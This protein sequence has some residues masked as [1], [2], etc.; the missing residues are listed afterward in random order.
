MFCLLYRSLQGSEVEFFSFLIPMEKLFER[1]I[2]K[3]IEG[4]VEGKVQV[5]R[6][7]GHL[8][9]KDR[10]KLFYLV[11]DVVLESDTITVIDTKYKLLDPEDRKMGI[12]QQDLYQMYA[13]CKEL[14]SK[15]CVL[16]YPEGLNG[17]ISCDLSLGKEGID[18][19]VRTLP[20]EN[21]FEN[22]R[23]S[24]EFVKRL[25]NVMGET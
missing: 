3:S 19:H 24:D 20:L 14:N 9:E 16:I 15:R 22:S 12:S 10:K 21:I 18:L 8:A 6:P 13:Y 5:Q 25:K 1:F 11:P 2:A 7:I 17:E 4:V 23:L